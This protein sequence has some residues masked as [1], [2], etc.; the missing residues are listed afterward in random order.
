M[1]CTNL[2]RKSI[3]PMYGGKAVAEYTMAMRQIINTAIED[4]RYTG[5]DVT[6]CKLVDLMAGSGHVTLNI[7]SKYKGCFNDGVMVDEDPCIGAL[8]KCAKD[9]EKSRELCRTMLRIGVS[10]ETFERAKTLW[11]VENREKIKRLDDV[12]KASIALIC[13]TYSYQG[14][15]KDFNVRTIRFHGD[16]NKER[17]YITRKVRALRGQLFS[18]YLKNIEIV[19]DDYEPTLKDVISSCKTKSRPVLITAD[20]PYFKETRSRSCQ[21]IYRKDDWTGEDHLKLIEELDMV[22]YPGVVFLM[23]YRYEKDE[24]VKGKTRT[25]INVYDTYIHEKY[26]AY[27][28]ANNPWRLFVMTRNKKGNKTEYLWVR[29]LTGE[30]ERLDEI[31]GDPDENFR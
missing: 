20:P 25:E 8:L 10:K 6:N 27:G 9:R 26:G 29:N 23:G 15:C 30:V 2:K 12:K 1:A 11:K 16:K 7:M 4:W 19:I 14:N 24:P 31:V 21:N 13:M 5:Y 22:E 18:L 17:Q 3:A 28:G